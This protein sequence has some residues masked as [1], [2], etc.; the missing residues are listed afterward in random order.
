MR[1]TL[2]TRIR[3]A[4]KEKG[5]AMRELADRTGISQS[6]ISNYEHNDRSPSFAKMA[7]IAEVLDISLDWFALAYFDD[8]EDSE[9]F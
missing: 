5:W 2:G 7:K 6:Q 3:E 4:R 8:E 1:K 9:K